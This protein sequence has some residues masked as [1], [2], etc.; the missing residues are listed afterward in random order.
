MSR[1]YILEEGKGGQRV[2]Q[3]DGINIP[4]IWAS[5]DIVDCAQLTTNNP[6]CVLFGSFSLITVGDG[7]PARTLWTAPS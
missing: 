5:Q 3:T 7:G 1:C 6:R 2:V 4:G